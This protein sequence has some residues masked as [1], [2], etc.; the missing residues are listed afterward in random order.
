M[1]DDRLHVR[2]AT[3]RPF[4][5][6]DASG[7]VTGFCGHVDLGTGIET[8][9]AQIVAEELEL[10]LDAVT[11][12]LGDTERTPDQGPTIASETIQVSAVPLRHAAA[13]L[14]AELAARGARRLN[15]PVAEVTFDAGS[16]RHGDAVVGFAALLDA[17]DHAIALDGTAPLKSPSDYTLVGRPTGRR[18]LPAKVAGRFAYIHD[19]VV[20]GMLHGHVV[21]PP[22]AGRDSGAFVGTSL[23]GYDEAAIAGREGFVA[24]V[25]E[26][27]FLGV[28][29]TRSDLA[30]PLAESLPV[31]WR[32]P[33]HL[34]DMDDLAATIREQPSTPRVLDVAGDFAEGLRDSDRTLRRSYV[35]PYQLHGSIGPS[36]AVADWASGDPVVWTGSQNPHMLRDDLSLLTGIPAHRIDVRRHQAAGCYGRN[37][38]DDV[39]GDALL[40][41]RAVG[42][43]VRVQLTRAQETLWEPKGAAQVMDVEGGLRDGCL[44]AYGL[45][46]WYPSNRGPNLA[47][48]LTGRIAP[49]LRPVEMGDRT[50]VPPYRIPNKRIIVHDLAPIVRAAWIRGVSALPN[51]FAH[52][53]FID[54]MA[55]EAGEDPVAFRLAHV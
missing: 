11:M 22:Y 23:L 38:A 25:R 31:R 9:L 19:V 49:D 35:W 4:L 7:G 29:A 26:A 54:E 48:L 21:R 52:E 39:A 2:D 36:C 55:A 27:D 10:P 14:R 17:G 46:T 40:L 44:H 37:C 33:P 50:I 41:S 24:V 43:P 47:L 13:T 16:V 30:R 15:A 3:G 45:D 20:D 12:V 5:T 42:H 51:T 34:P 32:T 53:C 6:L 28:V 8:A 18:D 1:G